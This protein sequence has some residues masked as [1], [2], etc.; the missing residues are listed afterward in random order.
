MEKLFNSLSEKL[1]D[2]LNVDEYLKISINGEHSQ[3][4]RFN[5]SKVRQSGIVEDAS[6]YMNLINFLYF[7]FDSFIIEFNINSCF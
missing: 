4:I 7:C 1:I 2:Q 6:L 3:F 5:Q